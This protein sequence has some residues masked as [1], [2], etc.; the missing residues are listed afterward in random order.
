MVTRCSCCRTLRRCGR[1]HVRAQ[2]G[3]ARLAYSLGG[4]VTMQLQ[5]GAY[6]C[7]I[8]ATGL[9]LFPSSTAEHDQAK[10]S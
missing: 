7:S 10:A 8:C 1:L 2:F 9:T 5:P 4:L 3:P 6:V